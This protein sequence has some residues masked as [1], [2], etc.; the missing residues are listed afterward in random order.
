MNHNFNVN[1]KKISIL[2]S[3]FLTGALILAPLGVNTNAF[4]QGGAANKANSA[5]NQAQNSAQNALCLSGALTGPACSNTS[6]QGQANTGGITTGQAATGGAGGN[7]T[8]GV[9][10]KQKVP[11][12]AQNRQ[13]QHALQELR[14]SMQEA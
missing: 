12:S 8:G 11:K 7:G 10:K 9:Q 5:I 2:L 14:S 4:A 1:G 13:M 6:N 3:I